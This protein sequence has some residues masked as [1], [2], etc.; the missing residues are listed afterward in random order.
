[1]ATNSQINNTQTGINEYTPDALLYGRKL[2]NREVCKNNLLE[3]KA[4]LNKH[5][6]NFGIIFGTLL[7]AVREGNFIEYDEDVDVYILE[8]EKQSF[9]NTLFELQKVGFNVARFEGDLLSIIR[10]NDY[11]DVYFFKKNIFNKRVCNGD[12]L[13]SSF[14]KTFDN[15]TF[16]DTEFNCP[17]NHILFLETAY[18]KDWKIPKKN[19]PAEVKKITTR[20]KIGIYRMFPNIYSLARKIYRILK[21]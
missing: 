21:S 15:I 10:D 3:F 1:M 17:A 4:I 20:L 11:I 6:V 13:K 9:L 18:G 7:G 14:F 16:L 5:N 12:S 2:I 19:K 8:E